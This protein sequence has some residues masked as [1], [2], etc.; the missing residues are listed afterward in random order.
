MQA[1]AD[2]ELLALG[3]SFLV[4][5]CFFSILPFTFAKNSK[6]TSE[7]VRTTHSQFALDALGRWVNAVTT[8]Q[9]R[10]VFYTCDC[11]AKHKMK[12]VKP[13]GLGKRS[14]RPYFSR[15]SKHH[16]GVSKNRTCCGGGESADHRN[17][18]HLLKALQGRFRFAVRRCCGCKSQTVETC[19]KG[20]IEIELVSK[21]G[22]WRY[23]CMLCVDTKP[24]MALEVVKTHFSSVNKIS[25]TRAGGVGLAEFRVEDVLALE[26]T[27]GG[28]LENLQVE[29]FLCEPCRVREE[30]RER[31]K[32]RARRMREEEDA[33]IKK[34][35]E[36]EEAMSRK[37]R[38]E[39]AE[40]ARQLRDEEEAKARRTREEGEAAKQ[41][42][43]LEKNLRWERT[44]AEHQARIAQ[45]KI[46]K[47][48]KTAE[49]I[50]KQQ[51]QSDFMKARKLEIEAEQHARTSK[52]LYWWER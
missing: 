35:R 29:V 45:K 23:D 42:H 12:L 11:P 52:R 25:S 44:K 38:E 31:E 2:G 20:T 26:D 32:A 30:E 21:D 50:V 28:W 34:I 5:K 18:K 4:L 46:S 39:K 19:N 17:A 43:L 49:D 16:S 3:K 15:V 7:M 14:F 41:A 9:R 37:I 47:K 36:E 6:N 24:V 22:R 1:L 8:K 10:G 13:L 27:N 48:R 33:R 51:P 40:R